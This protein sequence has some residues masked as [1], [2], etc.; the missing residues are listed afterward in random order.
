MNKLKQMGIALISTSLL[1]PASSVLAAT[2]GS[3]G[4]QSSGESQVQADVNK[5]IKIAD[6]SDVTFSSFMPGGSTSTQTMSFCV[7][8][9]TAPDSRFYDIKPTSPQ[10]DATTF[11]LFLNGTQDPTQDSD[12]MINYKITLNDADNNSKELTPDTVADNSSN[13]YDTDS[14]VNCSS[15]GQSLDVEITSDTSTNYGGT[16][17]DTLTLLVSPI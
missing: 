10:A 11:R 13:G 15:S 2:D 14:N 4:N 7:G 5:Q 1:L 3:Q 9:N 16:Y 6:M 17:T 12:K 8:M